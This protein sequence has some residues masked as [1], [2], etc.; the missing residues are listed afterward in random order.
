MSAGRECDA[1]SASFE[2]LDA[3]VLFELSDHLA[4]RRLGHLEP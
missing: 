4:E 3:D 1:A 2:Q